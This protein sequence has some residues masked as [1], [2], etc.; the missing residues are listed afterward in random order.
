MKQLGARVPEEMHK[1]LKTLAAEKGKTV[2]DLVDE[3]LQA[4][5]GE[6]HDRRQVVS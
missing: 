3:A 5:Y 1:R 6:S 2:Q 4:H